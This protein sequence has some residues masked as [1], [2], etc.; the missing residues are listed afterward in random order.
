M[1]RNADTPIDLTRFLRAVVERN[2]VAYRDDLA[3]DE[4]LLRDAAAKPEITAR[5]FCWMSRPHG[6]WCEREREVYLR[7]TAEHNIWTHYENATHGIKAFR[8]TVA[9]ESGGVLYGSVYALD[10]LAQVRRVKQTALPIVRVSGAYADGALFSVSYDALNSP[11]LRETCH[12]HGGIARIEY[13]PES[14]WELRELLRREHG[15]QPKRA[16]ASRTAVGLA[17]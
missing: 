2:T 13:H 5:T 4:T 7:G 6:T 8:I 15:L 14:E 9:G 11:Q 3:L 16:P 17:R 12:R 10:Y 1:S